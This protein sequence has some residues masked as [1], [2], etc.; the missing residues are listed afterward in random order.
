MLALETPEGA[1][2]D[3]DAKIIV[4]VKVT[5]TGE[6]PGKDVIL[7]WCRQAEGRLEKAAYILAGFSKTGTLQPGESEEI[8]L[9]TSADTTSAISLVFILRSFLWLLRARP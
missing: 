1:S 8:I 3:K 6:H 7:L 4:R 5:N 2:I 9:E